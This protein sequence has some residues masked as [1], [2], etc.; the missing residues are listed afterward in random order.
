MSNEQVT[1]PF[2]AK[3]ISFYAGSVVAVIVALL[4]KSYGWNFHGQI[5]G[6]VTSLCAIWWIF[7]PVPI[8]ITSLIPIAVFPMVGA[9]TSQ[10]VGQAYGHYL[11]LLLLG[12]FIISQAME[13]SGTHKRLAFGMISLFGNK[14][15]SLV[16]GFMAASALWAAT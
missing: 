14:G 3:K 13:R 1:N 15:K 8:P 6:G 4:L 12:G 5:V 16:F 9:M 10:Q 11:I 2:L 7:E